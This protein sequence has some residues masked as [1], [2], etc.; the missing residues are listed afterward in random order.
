MVYQNPQGPPS[1]RGRS[2]ADAQAE[3]KQWQ[4]DKTRL[5]ALQAQNKQKLEYGKAGFALGMSMQL[6][7]A[8]IGSI[9]AYHGVQ[10]QQADYR[11][12]AL[13]AKS[14]DVMAQLGASE[15]RIVASQIDQA[16]AQA[17]RQLGQAAAQEQAAGRVSQRA[18]G[19]TNA[20]SSAEVQASMRYKQQA[21]EL[22]VDTN[23]M[24]QRQSAERKRL[25]MMNKS[26]QARVDAANYM[27]MASSLSPGLAAATSLMQG[28]AQA[29]MSAAGYYGSK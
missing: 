27:D 20:G 4:A 16:G 10:A 5:E 8:V 26:R 18:R 7:A 29:G 17:R 2:Y 28:L 15:A 3:F 6:G 19:L 23:T 22:T 9:A 13:N 14:A 1:L 24:R 12:K 21:E 11:T 25:S